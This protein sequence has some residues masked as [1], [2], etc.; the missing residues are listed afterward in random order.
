MPNAQLDYVKEYKAGEI[1]EH[2][3][4]LYLFR[5]DWTPRTFSSFDEAFV[6]SGVLVNAMPP[7]IQSF[8]LRKLENVV[9]NSAASGELGA[10]FHRYYRP[11]AGFT[12]CAN[13]LRRFVQDRAIQ[14]VPFI[15]WIDCEVANLPE[16]NAVDFKF[17]YRPAWVS[18][19]VMAVVRT[20]YHLLSDRAVRARDFSFSPANGRVVAQTPAPPKCETVLPWEEV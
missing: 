17:N 15:Q 9:T 6:L 14:Q 18:G 13:A 19:P 5:R 11:N 1:V 3:G 20:T 2:N 10:V 7:Q 12:H 16:M 8:I 4:S